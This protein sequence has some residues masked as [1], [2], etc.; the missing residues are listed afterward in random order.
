MQISSQEMERESIMKIRMESR[1]VELDLLVAQALKIPLESNSE[2][3]YS[4]YTV[5]LRC[6]IIFV[7]RMTLYADPNTARGSCLTDRGRRGS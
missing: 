6:Q 4:N 2:N 5:K 3:S 7:R 1:T